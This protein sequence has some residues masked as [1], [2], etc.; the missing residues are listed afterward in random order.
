MIQQPTLM[1]IKLKEAIMKKK[2]GK[3][4]PMKHKDAKEDKKMMKKMV[5][6][7]CMK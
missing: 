3:K 4:E 1:A 6:K 5:K 7:D 2:D